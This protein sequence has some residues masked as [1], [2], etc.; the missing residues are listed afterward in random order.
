[1]SCLSKAIPVGGGAPEGSTVTVTWICAEA[2]P[3]EAAVIVTW[4]LP[5]T[6]P[7]E[8]TPIVRVAGSIPEVCVTVSHETFV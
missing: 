4:W 6:S 1:M 3:A 8:F 7:F 2:Y 5:T